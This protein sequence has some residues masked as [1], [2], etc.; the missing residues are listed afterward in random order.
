M[1]SLYPVDQVPF[2]FAMPGK[3]KYHTVI[4]TE[5]HMPAGIAG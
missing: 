4:I 5:D 3:I 2:A 1:L